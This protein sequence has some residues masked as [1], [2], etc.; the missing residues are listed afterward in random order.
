VQ[1][2]DPRGEVYFW[3]GSQRVEPGSRRGTDLEAVRR[4]AVSVTPLSLDL[5]HTP[6]LKPLRAV[7][8]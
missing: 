4:G 7:F 8:R 2:T 1:G 6:T 3:I 5:T